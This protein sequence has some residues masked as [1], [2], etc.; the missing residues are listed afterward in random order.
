VEQKMPAHPKLQKI[1]ADLKTLIG[2][3]QTWLGST[4]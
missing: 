1:D 3:L 2:S 4:H